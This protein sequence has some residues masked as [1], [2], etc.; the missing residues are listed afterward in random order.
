MHFI[1]VAANFHVPYNHYLKVYIP[2]RPQ[3]VA[4]RAGQ[5]LRAGEKSKMKHLLS[6]YI[7]R[8]ALRNKS[9]KQKM[10]TRVVN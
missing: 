1:K 7:F 10:L 4:H 3:W 8:T 5:K 9:N 2:F 6:D